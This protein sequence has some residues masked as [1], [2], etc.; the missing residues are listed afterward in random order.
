M[1]MNEIL[2]N[3]CMELAKTIRDN[4]DPRAITAAEDKI[5]A[6][7]MLM[8]G[9]VFNTYTGLY[10]ESDKKVTVNC[11]LKDCVH[12]LDERCSREDITI[13]QTKIAGFMCTDCVDYMED[14]K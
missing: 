11:L 5:I 9:Y 10:E 14:C 2:Q 8:A 3:D 4:R 7:A 1:N 13:S 12:N 6:T